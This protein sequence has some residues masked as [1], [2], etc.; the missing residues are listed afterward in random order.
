MADFDRLSEAIWKASEHH[1][2]QHD[3]AGLPYI[4]H[5][6]RVMDTLRVAGYGET[7]L[8][9][10]VLHDTVED[11]DLT[12]DS[13]YVI[14]GGEVRDLVDALTRRKGEAYLDYIARVKEAGGDAVA[15]KL[16]DI[17]DNLKPDR[18]VIASLVDRYK[19]A[20]EILNG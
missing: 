6:I 15:I 9:A 17:G 11:T 10:A 5:P 4:L 2:G 8:V 14:F 3:K 12:L 18:P 16:S 1:Y 7:V 20:K 13:I 19:K